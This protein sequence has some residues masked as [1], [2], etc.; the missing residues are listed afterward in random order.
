MTDY[1]ARLNLPSKPYRKTMPT[2]VKCKLE[3]DDFRDAPILGPL[4]NAEIALDV[5][6]TAIEVRHPRHDRDQVEHGDLEL[7][8]AQVLSALSRALRGFIVDYRDIV[9]ERL[10]QQRYQQIPY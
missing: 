1:P 6:V 5:L 9:F 3:S 2:M 10:Q 7:R 4:Y 8:R